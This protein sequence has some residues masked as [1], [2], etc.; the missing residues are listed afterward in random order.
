MCYAS[1]RHHRYSVTDVTV[2]ITNKL[3]T[4]TL[5]T[6]EFNGYCSQY[7]TLTQLLA[8]QNDYLANLLANAQTYTTQTSVS[9]IDG[10]LKHYRK[11]HNTKTRIDEIITQLQEVEQTI[12][13]IMQYFDIPAGTI[14]TAAIVDE[15]EFEIWADDNDS[16]QV[17]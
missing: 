3:K 9:K 14:L 10:I 4:L 7:Y 2:Q 8:K 12:L 6:G 16:V 11:I 13:M 1:V 17:R 15:V 5:M